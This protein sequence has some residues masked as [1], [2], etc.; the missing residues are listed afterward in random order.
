M[1]VVE[2][3][4][5]SEDKFCLALGYFDGMHLAHRSI[6]DAAVAKAHELGCR[7]AISTFA[8]SPGGKIPIYPYHERKLLYEDCGAEICLTM[9]YAGICGEKGA[10]FFAK[11]MSLYSP[12]H[13]VCGENYTFG[14]D[15]LG[16]RELEELCGSAGVGLTVV[17]TVYY[18]G[19]KVSS[20]AVKNFLLA[21]DMAA[22]RAM[23]V[24]PYHIRGD[25]V[26]GDGR[27]HNIGI[28]T[29]NMR[30][31]SG[32]TEIR[33]G[34]YGTYAELGGKKYRAVTN[35][36]PRPTFMQNK[37]AVET[38]LIGYEG[39]SLLHERAT[40]YFYR[41][42]RPIRK[43]ADAAALVARIQKDKE[44]KDLC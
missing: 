13:L 27:G 17:P 43:Y 37:F 14:S 11:L 10:E 29:I 2:F 34:V 21:G 18:G 25:V 4:K 16:V 36:G 24:M 30:F 8:D 22:A 28:P 31:P 23:L 44:W 1:T 42:L 20:T 35:V 7:A 19:V 38:N 33:Q 41:Y 12:V 26:S 32:V 6:L 39:G 5:P 3:G 9:Y 40:V 15:L